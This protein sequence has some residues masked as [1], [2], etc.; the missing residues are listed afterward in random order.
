MRRDNEWLRIDMLAAR[1]RDEPAAATP[2]VT[3]P[4]TPTGTP[5]ATPPP[6]A[7]D[8]EGDPLSW[9]A[10]LAELS[11]TR[12]GERAAI[13]Q[14]IGELARLARQRFGAGGEP[15]ELDARIEALIA[16]VEDLADAAALAGRRR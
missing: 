14:L 13:T 10:R 6:V 12:F 4:G 3:P 8:D 1:W 16:D 15:G 2:T 5:A 9:C 11:H 7:D